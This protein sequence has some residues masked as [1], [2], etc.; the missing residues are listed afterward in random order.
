MIR[1]LVIIGSGP[2]GLT[3]AIYAARAFLNP[4]L[5]TGREPGGQLTKTTV[6]ENFP[7]F[8][9]GIT[10]PELME[11]MMEQA[12][13]FGTEILSGEVER[14]DFKK[15]PFIIQVNGKTINALSVIIATG[16]H[17]RMLGIEAEERYMGHGVST[18][19]TCDGFFFRDMDVVVVGGGDTALEEAIFLTRFA[20]EVTIIH[21]R[22][23]L[24]AGKILQ[25][26]AFKNSKIKFLWN[27][28]VE[29]ILGD[30][31][32]K[33]RGVV[34]RD[35]KENTRFVKEC[36]GVFIAIGHEPNTAVFK[37]QVEMDER[38]YI[39]VRDFVKTNIPG[40][41]AAGDVHDHRFRQAITAAAM[42][43]MA[44]MEAEKYLS[45]RT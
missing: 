31:E 44:A 43:C 10:G 20:R 25:D 38:N 16:A 41:F 27:S 19:A 17:P 5:I 18:C 4:L 3:A 11:R 36:K 13:K 40:I 28:V 7:G 39:V 22:D 6:V 45:E 2:A 33:V 34:V 21:R 12:K 15:S 14:V 35:K 23:K 1:N 32:G 37:G 8:P 30:D 26:R 29:D 42:G 24:R 9:E